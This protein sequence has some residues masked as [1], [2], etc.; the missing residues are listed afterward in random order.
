MVICLFCPPAG[1]HILIRVGRGRDDI[2]PGYYSTEK[3]EKQQGVFKKSTGFS[4]DH[5][6][7]WQ[8]AQRKGEKG[9]GIVKK[10]IL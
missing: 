2:Q 6:L 10:R 1:V 3:C 8:D 9:S 5:P 7:F 4:E